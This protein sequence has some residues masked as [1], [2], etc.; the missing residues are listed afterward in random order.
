M[1]SHVP[2]WTPE[3]LERQGA[4]LTRLARGL[5]ADEHAAEDL[6]QDTWLRVLERPP[7]H[8][9]GLRGWMATVARNLARNEG[10][11]RA[12]RAERERAA[13]RHE[14]LPPVADEVAQQAA[15]RSLVET[16][17]NLDEPYRG[18]LWL[19]FFRGLD[20][21]HIAEELGRPEATVRSQLQRALSK[22]RD[23]L[24]RQHGGRS[25]WLSALTPLA[26]AGE[27]GS[28]VATGGF[29]F[30][31]KLVPIAAA[32]VLGAGATWWTLRST[33]D[34]SE[35]DA[36]VASASA[37]GSSFE[38]STLGVSAQ[39]P[40]SPQEEREPVLPAEAK[41]IRLS[42]RVENLDYEELGL[43]RSPAA[44]IRLEAYTNENDMFRKNDPTFV[45]TDEEGRF[46]IELDDPGTRPLDLPLVGKG[47]DVY[48]QLRGEVRLEEGASSVTGI[49]LERA[50]HGLLR[51]EIVDTSGA[52]L[53]AAHLVYL[54]LGQSGRR[55]QQAEVDEEGHFRIQPSG[56]VHKLS[57]ELAG[58]TQLDSPRAL[59]LAP[60]GYE[61]VRLVMARSAT[62]ELE[63]VDAAGNGIPNA[64]IDV[65]P[66]DAELPRAEETSGYFPARVQRHNRAKT[67]AEGRVR[68]EGVWADAKLRVESSVDRLHSISY[69]AVS[70]DRLVEER[71]SGRPI[72]L[73]AGEVRS[74]RA[75][76]GPRHEVD[77]RV[78]HLG[79]EPAADASVK[80]Y[81]AGRESDGDPVLVYEGGTADDG[82]FRFDLRVPR[83]VG[84][85]L[86]EA[87]SEPP[88]DGGEGGDRLMLS[89][90]GYAGA[91][92]SAGPDDLP[93]PILRAS[94]TVA[95]E[96][97]GREMRSEADDPDHSDRPEEKEESPLE[98]VLDSAHR[99]Q[100]RVL[101]AD[102]TRVDLADRAIQVQ[103][104][105]SEA[106]GPTLH[107]HVLEDGSFLFANVLNGTYDLFVSGPPQEGFTISS[108]FLRFPGI[109]AGSSGVELKLA[110]SAPIE[111]RIR[112]S[113][114][115][116]SSLRVLYGLWFDPTGASGPATTAPRTQSV[117]TVHGWPE[118][119]Y[120]GDFAQGTEEYGSA[121]GHYE[122]VP[123]ESLEPSF[124]DLL[125]GSYRFGVHA[126]TEQGPCFP[127]VGAWQRL[128]DGVYEL[129]FVL[130]RS[131]LAHG[132]LAQA[133][134][135]RFWSV[136]VVDSK[137]QPIT[138]PKRSGSD[139]RR[140]VDLSA[141]GAFDLGRAPVGNF[142]VRLGTREQLL[143]G[144]YE[145]ELEVDFEVGEE[146]E[147]EF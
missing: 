108:R 104:R 98:L 118:S 34:A 67:D 134:P 95:L 62:L 137:G 109:R 83:L 60:G 88:T 46:V 12:R 56:Y 51:G 119:M 55:E 31:A 16:V 97:L 35:V 114:V 77:G 54:A 17:L 96:A 126:E 131:T 74:L 58:Y 19:R 86:V 57:V 146:T 138:L 141:A 93:E 105:L 94:A 64:Q 10:R 24:E 80:V 20:P 70:E 122:L 142:R 124:H 79:G 89:A 14:A 115:E 29:A 38:P 103:A 117:S 140:T 75:I 28:G 44:G 66:V 9:A 61:D 50:P 15:L 87:S 37:L 27:V 121:L 2:H 132:R 1:H 72:V 36:S 147:I 5:I 49:V 100:G 41:K 92:P 32:L 63:V 144:G 91:P 52:P 127:V 106:T 39:T 85:L 78:L 73:A 6:A 129:D 110:E 102:G 130:R 128:E 101:H 23:E 59:P 8:D 65:A 136:A 18:V 123:E 25:Q 84:P 11:G 26:G 71:A 113:G 53:P 3:T 116:I 125:P 48:R 81:D 21:A 69:E 107:P 120:F 133:D 145:R 143:A 40:A 43:E 111:V 82:S 45:E 139:A 30:A 47:S 135:A 76:W 90:L 4:F 13:A 22:M 99:I 68:L 42:G 112:T 33:P 7:R